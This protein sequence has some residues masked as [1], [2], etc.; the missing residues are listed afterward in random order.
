M[1]STTASRPRVANGSDR[2][3]RR[4]PAA[5]AATKPTGPMRKR[6]SETASTGPAL[7]S[8]GANGSPS[9][10]TWSSKTLTET[11]LPSRGGISKKESCRS[12]ATR[13]VEVYNPSDFSHLTLTTD[14]NDLVTQ[15]HDRMPAILAPEDYTRWLSDRPCRKP[16]E[17]VMRLYDSL[18]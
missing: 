12:A 14:G 10:R 6:I 7:N 8:P 15:I 1:A 5:C 13:R 4:R 3:N 16:L 9:P 17:A 11:V 18:E 2:R